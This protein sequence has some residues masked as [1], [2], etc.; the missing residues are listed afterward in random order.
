MS[1]RPQGEE[2][3]GKWVMHRNGLLYQ[4]TG[5]RGVMNLGPDKEQCLGLEAKPQNCNVAESE[6]VEWR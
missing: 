4:I 2:W 6:I 1:E 3:V 5:I